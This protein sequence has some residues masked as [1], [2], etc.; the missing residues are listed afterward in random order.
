M[1]NLLAA[2][3]VDLIVVV[4]LRG[5]SVHWVV[6]V[7]AFGVPPPP[8]APN[9]VASGTQQADDHCGKDRNYRDDN[10]QN[11]HCYVVPQEEVITRS[12]V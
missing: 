1:A 10:T 12:T 2:T 6:E 7:H 4:V 9:Q 3:N 8:V 11:C 5:F